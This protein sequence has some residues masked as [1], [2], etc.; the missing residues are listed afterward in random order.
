MS[1]ASFSLTFQGLAQTLNMAGITLNGPAGLVVD[2]AGDVY[3]VDKGNSR[4]V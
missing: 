4:I 1:W 3:I 2:T